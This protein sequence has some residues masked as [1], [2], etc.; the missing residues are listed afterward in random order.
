MASSFGSVCFG[1]A[2]SVSGEKL[3]ERVMIMLRGDAVGCTTIQQAAK[4]LGHASSVSCGDHRG[5]AVIRSGDPITADLL[6]K[7]EQ[8]GVLG[9]FYSECLG[10]EK[11]GH[12]NLLWVEGEEYAELLGAA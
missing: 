12:A 10:R 3:G 9:E 5:H 2:F 1:Y 6:S 11:R 4:L 8:L 7:I